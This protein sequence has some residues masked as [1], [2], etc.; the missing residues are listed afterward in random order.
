M[1]ALVLGFGLRAFFSAVAYVSE[2]LEGNWQALVL[3]V[4]DQVFRHSNYLHSP[5]V[6]SKSLRQFKFHL[7]PRVQ[8]E[9]VYERA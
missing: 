4:G 1:K 2:I 9:I 6:G 5:N 3:P 8:Q 7:Q